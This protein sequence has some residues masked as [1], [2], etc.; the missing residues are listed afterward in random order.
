MD[1]ALEAFIAQEIVASNLDE[2]TMVPEVEENAKKQNMIFAQISES[3]SRNPERIETQRHRVTEAALTAA[4]STSQGDIAASS[5][6]EHSR[7]ICFALHEVAPDVLT[8][9][10]PAEGRDADQGRQVELE[11]VA[12]DVVVERKEVLQLALAEAV[13]RSRDVAERVGGLE[14]GKDQSSADAWI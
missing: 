12:K 9:P 7:A 10:R 2:L 5:P 8:Q 14:V 1:E 3:W 13:A 6:I 11:H 4:A